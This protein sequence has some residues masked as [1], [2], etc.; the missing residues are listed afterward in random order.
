MEKI[1]SEKKRIIKIISLTATAVGYLTTLIGLIFFLTV[2]REIIN[3]FALL[4]TIFTL[5]WVIGAAAIIFAAKRPAPEYTAYGLFAGLAISAAAI[6]LVVLILF[7]L[8]VEMFQPLTLSTEAT[9]ILISGAVFSLIGA[10]LG[11]IIK[12]RFPTRVAV[13][14]LVL[15]LTGVVWAETQNYAEFPAAAEDRSFIFENGE[16]GY[17]TF[18]IPSLIALDKTVLNEKCGLSLDYDYLLATA[19]AR[20]SSR[21]VGDIDIVGKYSV[22]NGKTWSQLFVL[23]S[24]ENEKGKCGNPT[25]V[26]DTSNGIL[27]FVYMRATAAS[28]YDYRT[29]NAQLRINPDFSLSLEKEILMSDSFD[30]DVKKGAA[31]GV[32]DNTVMAGPGKGVQLA[33]G[34]LIVPCSNKGKA[35]VMLSDDHGLTWRRGGIAGEGNE[36]EAAI[37]SDGELVMVIRA[38]DKCYTLHSKQYQRFAYSYDGGETWAQQAADSTLKTPLCMTSLTASGGSLYCT[39][40]DCFLTRANLSVAQSEDG[41]KSWRTTLLYDGASGY[42]CITATSDG[43]LFVLAEIGKVNYNEALVFI[44]L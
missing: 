32:N 5:V 14:L 20:E 25:P 38:N 13:T 19:E 40:P 2:N 24:V 35:F 22:D 28:G 11:L 15:M 26:L 42:S 16:G 17:Y 6:T 31:D 1:A 30:A 7:T 4:T 41:G 8:A 44:A 18:R 12:S 43:D 36:C 9:A 21:D 3:D 39:Y 10:V 27:N 33:S 23:F 29:Y 34:R 37:A